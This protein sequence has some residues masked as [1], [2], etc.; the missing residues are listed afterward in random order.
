MG[1]WGVNRAFGV[2]GG[3]R[4]GHLVTRAYG[5]TARVPF[6]GAAF[7]YKDSLIVG[8]DALFDDGTENHAK[9]FGL[10]G[11]FYKPVSDTLALK[12]AVYVRAITFAS[13]FVDDR[14][15]VAESLRLSVGIA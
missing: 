7:N 2:E 4:A 15:R 5:K 6:L 10:R 12:F 11:E 3:L 13:P 9:G 14:R 1:R 8:G